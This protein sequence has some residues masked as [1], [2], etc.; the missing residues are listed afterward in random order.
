MTRAE[1]LKQVQM[2]DFAL[3]DTELFLDTHPTNETALIFYNDTR[4]AYW[5][6]VAA[7]EEQF[8]P[9]TAKAT[10]VN[11]GWTWGTAPWPW[12]MED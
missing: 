12:E 8:G 1:A 5:Q 9:L 3:K 10:N 6:A 2:Y 11:Q 4:N 7:Y